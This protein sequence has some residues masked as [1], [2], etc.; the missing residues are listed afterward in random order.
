MPGDRGRSLNRIAGGKFGALIGL[1]SLLCLAL[2][3]CGG[4]VGA[5]GAPTATPKARPTATISTRGL[6][7]TPAPPGQASLPY[8]LPATWHNAPGLSQAEAAGPVAYAFAPSDGAFGYLCATSSASLYTTNDGGQSWNPLRAAPFTGCERISIDAQDAYDVFAQSP[9]AAQTNGIPDGVDLWRSRDGGATWH[10]LGRVT[11]TGFR[12]SWADLAV[13]GSQLIGQVSIDEE[14]SLQ[15]YLFASSDGGYTWSPFAQ[16][17]ANQGY[18][19]STFTVL[20]S[21]IYISGQKSLGPSGMAAPIRPS[22]N[23][24]HAAMRPLEAPLS[25]QPPSPPVFWRSLDG[26]ATWSQATLP[27]ATLYATPRSD[28]HGSYALSVTTTDVSSQAQSP[29]YDAAIWWSADSG[30]TWTRLPDMQG[31]E[32]GY[33]LGGGASTIAL[34]AEQHAAESQ[35]DD[36]GIFRIQP[37]DSSPA[38]Q[39]LAAGGVQGWQTD[40][41][42]SG[43][44]LWGVGAFE[45]DTHL[46]YVNVA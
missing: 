15:D 21:A 22:A 14:G 2:A 44:R 6:G 42:S 11:G 43:L 7:A 38:W 20:G 19:I 29:L 3:A 27:G 33:V 18:T 4:R 37:S 24:A 41:T 13:V 8:L 10:K 28:G 25:G 1:L 5:Q 39:P 9:S 35:P 45:S 23:S 36:A 34:A 30:A 32:H 40:M 26:G 16:S 17:V 46:K 31:L 12:L